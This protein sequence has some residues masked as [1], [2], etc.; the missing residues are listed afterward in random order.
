[1][2]ETQ[3]Q[4]SSVKARANAANE[5]KEKS[6]ATNDSA[7]IERALDWAVAQSE[8]CLL[9]TSDAADE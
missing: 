2:A 8:D 1:M 3:P 4:E 5:A 6:V 9:Y 7:D